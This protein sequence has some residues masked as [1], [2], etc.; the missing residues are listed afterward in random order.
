[1]RPDV[2]TLARKHATFGAEFG[3]RWIHMTAKTAAPLSNVHVLSSNSPWV[4]GVE[5]DASYPNCSP[6]DRHRG[7]ADRPGKRSVQLSHDEL[8]AD[9]CAERRS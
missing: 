5:P 6:I 1:M 4:P 9:Q 8:L 2:A 7:N 3:R